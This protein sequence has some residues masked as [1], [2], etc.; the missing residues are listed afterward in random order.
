VKNGAKR[1]RVQ[2]GP[3]PPKV[4]ADQLVKGRS[5]YPPAPAWLQRIETGAH[6]VSTPVACLRSFPA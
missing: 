6:G 2:E 4:A 3:D 5:V 1:G